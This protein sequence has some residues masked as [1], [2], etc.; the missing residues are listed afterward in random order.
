MEKKTF[1]D[2]KQEVAEKYAHE[3]FDI[4]V[5]KTEFMYQVEDLYNEAAD[6][7][8]QYCREE[9][10]KEVAKYIVDGYDANEKDSMSARYYYA[11]NHCRSILSGLKTTD[12]NKEG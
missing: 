2:F 7:W 11:Y 1:E 8:G 3:D 9:G 5:K 6:L 4:A 12:S 10:K